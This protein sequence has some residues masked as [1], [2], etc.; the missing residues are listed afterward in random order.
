[1]LICSW[2]SQNGPNMLLMAAKGKLSASLRTA[3]LVNP[4]AGLPHADDIM[5][6]RRIVI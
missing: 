5:L 4:R 1:M 3:A 2:E 6:R